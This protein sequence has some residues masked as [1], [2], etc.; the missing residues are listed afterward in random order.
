[1]PRR[2]PSPAASPGSPLA[3]R[4]GAEDGFT[5]V[6]LLTVII[7]LGILTAV[8]IPSY[9]SLK[10]RA[11]KSAAM[12]AVRSAGSDI[13]A[14]YADNGTF[15]GISASVLKTSYDTTLDTTVF[16]VVSESSGSSFMA[17]AKSHGWYGYKLG[18]A[19]SIHFSSIAPTDCTL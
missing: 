12:T 8:A 9:L 7:I 17:C 15:N 18:P 4:A 5:L 19:D 3:L 1:V 16:Q 6:E 11:D 13:E 2:L 14:Y 10:D